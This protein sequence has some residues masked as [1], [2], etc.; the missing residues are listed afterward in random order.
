MA[1]P[2]SP[3]LKDARTFELPRFIQEYI[4]FFIIKKTTYLMDG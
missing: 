1:S 3:K 2:V 4:E